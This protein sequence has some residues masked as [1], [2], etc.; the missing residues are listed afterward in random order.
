LGDGIK[1][2]F[3]AIR[4]KQRYAFARERKCDA[5]SDAGRGAGHQ[6]ALAPQVLH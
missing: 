1:S 4:Y 3:V 5:P 2:G 6:R